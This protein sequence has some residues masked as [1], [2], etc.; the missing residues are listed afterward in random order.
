MTVLD[1]RLSA[2]RPDL[3]DERLRGSVEAERFIAGR[4]ARIAAPVADIRKAPRPDSGMS[5]QCLMGDRVR[6]FDEAE[7]Y[8][9][10]QADHDGYVGYM[11]ASDLGPVETVPT[12]RVIAPRTFVY[13]GPDL[14]SPRSATLSLGCAVEIVGEAET[15]GTRYCVLA[16]G[17][18]I[19]TAH[20]GSIESAAANYVEVAET[21]LGTPYLWGGTSAFGIDCSGLVQ[22][23][24]RM[25]GRDVPRDSDMQ[26]KGLGLPLEI[27]PDFSGLQ[28]GDL[29]FW[30]GHVAIMTDPATI[31]HA[32]GHTMLVSR[33][34][35]AAAVDRIGYLYGGP[36]CFRRP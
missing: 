26:A 36:S 3:A 31:I 7:G 21:L 35:L 29:V 19:V 33:E 2:F 4:P 23:A 30:K 34:G 6:V 20:L 11:A 5:T 14:R 15:R 27:A 22:L 16:S 13:S 28:R 18:A 10:V 24:M 12:H 8:A 32:S 9:W 1:S 25:T 17:E